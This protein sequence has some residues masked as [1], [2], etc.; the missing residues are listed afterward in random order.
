MTSLRSRSKAEKLAT[1]VPTGDD[2]ATVFSE[3]YEV[4]TGRQSFSPV[5]VTVT[6]TRH[7][8]TRHSYVILAPLTAEAD[9]TMA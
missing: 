1:T 2:S 7:S 3:L 4:N 5:S 9:Y 6:C 8:Y